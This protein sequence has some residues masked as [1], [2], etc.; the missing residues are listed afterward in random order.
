[1]KRLL[2]TLLILNGLLLPCGGLAG[3][4]IFARLSQV[5]LGFITDFHITNATQ[6]SIKTTPIGTVGSQGARY[7]LHQIHRK[8]PTFDDK[9]R[10]GFEVLPN[11]TVE[12]FYDWDDI[13]F[14]EIVIEDHTGQLS[15]LVV[16]PAP[17]RNQY[18]PPATNTFTITDASPLVSVPPD[19]MTAYHEAQKPY[20]L[21]IR[22]YLFFLPWITFP[23]LLWLRFKKVGTIE[24]PTVE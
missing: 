18:H 8:Q 15:Q 21:P 2:T 23:F 10:G 5:Q 7:P 13:N 22:F 24:S 14:S 12:L 17:T 20:H 19:V 16:D 11:A 6:H 9:T 3:L 4:V 1:M